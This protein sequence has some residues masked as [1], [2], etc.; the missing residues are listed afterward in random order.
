MSSPWPLF[1]ALGFVISEIGVFLNVVPLSV[2]GLLLFAGSVAGIV[3]ES[4]YA[5]RPWGTLSIVGG[6]LVALGAVVVASQLLPFEGVSTALDTV[7]SGLV[8]PDMNGVIQRG[9]SVLF[10]GVIAVAAAQAAQLVERDA[11]AL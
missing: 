9:V 8:G 10:A 7:W 5:E 3:Q 4:G 11:D 6:L 2:G 1:V